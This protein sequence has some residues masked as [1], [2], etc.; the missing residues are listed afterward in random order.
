MV[1]KNI[2]SKFTGG[3]NFTPYARAG[4]SIPRP[5]GDIIFATSPFKLMRTFARAGDSMLKSTKR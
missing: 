5:I 2:L 1:V 3:M 4:D